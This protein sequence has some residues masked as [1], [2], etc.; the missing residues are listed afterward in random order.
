METSQWSISQR[1]T[2]LDAV[3]GCNSIKELVRTSI[4]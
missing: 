3:T 2:T 1:P 4:K